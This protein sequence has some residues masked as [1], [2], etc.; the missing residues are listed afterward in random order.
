MKN[1][2]IDLEAQDG[3][4]KEFT[5]V[6]DKERVGHGF[7]DDNILPSCI[8]SLTAGHPFTTS[9]HT[10]ALDTV[11][12]QI[13][14]RY[15]TATEARWLW[16]RGNDW[17][18]WRVK[19]TPRQEYFLI[20]ELMMKQNSLVDELRLVFYNSRN[21]GY[22]YLEAQ[23]LKSEI[24]S[25]CEVLRGFP[26]IRMSTLS[27]VPES[28]MKSC[29]T[30]MTGSEKQVFARGQ[31]VQI[32][33]GLYRGD[34][35]LV[36]KDYLDEES[37]RGVK[38]MVVPQLSLSDEDGPS[39]SKRKR[40]PSRPPPQLFNLSQC[41]QD[42]LV[43]SSKNHIFTYKSWHFKYSLQVKTYNG[44]SLT[45]ACKISTSLCC[46]FMDTKELVG[47]YIYENTPIKMSSMPIPSFWQFEVGERVIIHSESGSK[48]GVICSPLQ[49]ET[50]QCEVDLGAEGMCVVAAH[51]L[52]KPIILGDFIKVLAR[53]HVRKLGFIVAQSNA[54]LGIC[55][56]SHSNGL[57]F[58]VHVNS[59]KLAT[60]DISN[61][62]VPWVNVGVMIHS[63]PFAG[64]IGT[65][66]DV[67]G[68][69][70]STIPPSKNDINIFNRTNSLLS[71]YCPLEGNEFQEFSINSS[72]ETMRMGPV[73]WLG[74]LVDFVKGH[75]KGEHRAIWDI[76]R[77]AINPAQLKKQSGLVLTMERYVFT[78]GQANKVV[79]V[80]YED[81]RYR[82]L[83]IYLRTHFCLCDL[84]MP[85]ARQSF[86]LPERIYEKELT[87][88]EP[89]PGDTVVGSFTPLPNDFE[90][91]AIFTGVW[92]PSCP[93]PVPSLSAIE[94]T[95][96]TSGYETPSSSQ[97]PVSF[98]SQSPAQ[99]TPASPSPSPASRSPSPAPSH[100]ILNLK[101][102]GIP[103]KVDIN[104]GDHDMS[105]KKGGIFVET[106]IGEG[107]ISVFHRHS[108]KVM[109][110][111]PHNLVISFQDW[112]NPAREK[113]LMVVA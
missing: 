58:Q 71:V 65:V 53:I 84:F 87:T 62:E 52:E 39:T 91:A 82:R 89:V 104:S 40:P 110:Y 38:V 35:G 45:A 85:T 28:D 59:V 97:S 67:V 83:T 72:I 13:E 108:P 5:D 61:T 41:K 55:I 3:S 74:L 24:N 18:L 54:L 76:N 26:D 21:V 6:E 96:N 95:S 102:V 81:V 16:R 34:V 2:F 48:Q 80:D 7:I 90:K 10:T 29:L 107:R 32:M 46:L 43:R 44:I 37:T 101:L 78:P 112:P 19:C 73:P 68:A 17:N 106:V 60:P 109:D 100:W 99:W 36:I 113:G 70:I 57:D 64:S 63:G 4:D 12:G 42:Q 98:S 88:N 111:I 94:E 50:L 20:Y 103:M 56:S 33:R 51:K 49:Q 8:A 93:M 66:K 31:W 105:K 69:I 92:S 15:L 30:L 14:D 47:K 75:Y 25:L 1:Q 27:I 79:N 11:V 9:S 23:F 86:Y 77:Y 22:L